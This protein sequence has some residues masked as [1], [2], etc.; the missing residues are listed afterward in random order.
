MKSVEALRAQATREVST[1]T[2]AQRMRQVSFQRKKVCWF[3]LLFDKYLL[4][5]YY[6]PGIHLGAKEKQETN[7]QKF[8]SSWSLHPKGESE[9]KQNK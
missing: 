3:S 9:M 8:L 7:R 2:S 4:S 1:R 6:M 5:N